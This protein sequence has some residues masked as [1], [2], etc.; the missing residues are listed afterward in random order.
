MKLLRHGPAGRE[1]PGLLDAQGQ[2]RDLTGVVPDIAG[3]TLTD[4]GR[5]ALRALDPQALPMVAPGVRLGPCVGAAG[6]FV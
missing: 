2:V 6:K 1:R 4:A 5:A 3:P